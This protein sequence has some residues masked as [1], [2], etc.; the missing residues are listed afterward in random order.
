MQLQS[1]FPA[2]AAVFIGVLA[3]SISLDAQTRYSITDLGPASSPFSQATGLNNTGLVTGVAASANGFQHAVAWYWGVMTDISRPGLGGLNS[4]GG[5]VNQFGQIMGLAET[6]SRDPYNEN[7]C[8]F[9][10]SSQCLTFLWDFGTMTPLPTLGGTNSNYGAINNL[11][12]IAGIA[13]T[14]RRDP[15]CR[16]GPAVNGTGP[17]V[18]DFE[19]VVWGPQ[20][21]QI[22]AL[23]PLPGDTVGMGIGINDAG[24]VVGASGTCA[25]TVLPGFT[26]APHAVLWEKDGTVRSLPGLGGSAPDVTVL[27][28]GSF[29]CSINNR[30]VIAGQSTLSD[31][32]TWHPVLWHDGLIADLGVLPG[33]AVGIA[34]GINDRGDVVGASVS[35]PG[36][37]TG[38]PRAYLWR[39]GVMTDLNSLIPADS[40]LYL[41]TAFAI[42]NSGEIAGFGVTDA[43]D[44]HGFV[45]KPCHGESEGC[46]S[47][48]ATSNR[49]EAKL[50]TPLSE[51][52]RKALLQLGLRGH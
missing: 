21:G 5:G 44:L 18:L 39:N 49:A 32:K 34:A 6:S 23:S 31:N 11:G 17:Q 20:A 26:A 2:S 19:A 3:A 24:Q 47:S 52:A 46:K 33:D 50:R 42:N 13:E 48:G 40:P 35:A 10:T 9:G 16:P 1:R 25:N 43:G 14:N 28:A 7:F 36:P 4:A 27:G 45:A 51:G 8:G 38:N 15:N 30:G 41:L 37:A 22:R 29:G 12:E